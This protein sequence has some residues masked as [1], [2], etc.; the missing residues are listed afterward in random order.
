M[1]NLAAQTVDLPRRGTVARWGGIGKRLFGTPFNAVVTL[2]C[3]AFLAVSLP[4]LLRWA[5]LD[6]TWL[7]TA[8]E[9]CTG[10]G[11][12][13][14]F[15]RVRLDQFIYGFYPGGER[16]R[17]DLAGLLIVLAVA[18]LLVPRVPRKGF[19]AL[20]GLLILPVVVLWLL[21]GGALGLPYVETREWG[22]LMLTL[23]MALYGA[24]IAV[25]LGIVLALGRQASL[26]VVRTI[27]VVII[28]FWR[29]VPIIAVIFLASQ[30]LPIILPAGMTVDKVLRA[31]IGLAL[32]IA[33]YM[34][35]VV[36][37]GLQ[38]IPQGQ[39]EAARGL[40]L[41]YWQMTGFIVLPQALRLVVPGLVNEFISLLKNT[42]LVL[43]V[44]LFDLLG[45]AQAALA[46]PK[47]VG[48][49]LEAYVFV[50]LVFWLLC[51]A[52]SRWS[53]RLERR[54]ATGTRR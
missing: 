38:A 50:G 5:L 42:T 30:L 7:G 49:N 17:V 32:V 12:C 41:G 19:I 14:V 48:L 24:L 33:A 28:E 6:A 15:V 45:I 13:W 9:A 34:A 36:R 27:C 37:G 16:W 46:D 54:L 21:V 29:G 47:W 1:T 26:P 44:S 35:E 23:F 8:R 11:A 43:I 22:G 2:L 3:L 4:P 18:P 53:L 39:Y 40:G 25:P 51:F 31:L 10:T 20:A 52:M